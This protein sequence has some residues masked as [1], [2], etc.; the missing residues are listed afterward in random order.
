MIRSDQEGDRVMCG[1]SDNE[2]KR[3]DDVHVLSLHLQLLQRFIVLCVFFDFL[4][5]K[6]VI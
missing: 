5:K 6:K 1:H 3:E 2:D 4:H